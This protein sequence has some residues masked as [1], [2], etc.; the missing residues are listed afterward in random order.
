MQ[1]R[2]GMPLENILKKDRAYAESGENYS[3][4][5]DR[6]GAELDREKGRELLDELDTAAG[7]YSA[8][9]GEAAYR[10]GFHDGLSVG[11]EHREQKKKDKQGGGAGN[12]GESVSVFTVAD[13][14]DLI[15]IYDAYI[16]M[17]KMF[18]GGE[19]VFT[20]GE[21]I[22]GAMSRIYKV[23]GKHMASSMREGDDPIGYCILSDDSKAPE[24]RA[25][26]LMGKSDRK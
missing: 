8:K 19:T 13:M 18:F 2:M 6:I 1:D 20:Y 25:R 3:R 22:F 5:V 12:A 16:Q 26:L 23:I 4:A 14:T 10:L 9:Y 21:G 11:L 17:D 24:E 7:D 15:Y